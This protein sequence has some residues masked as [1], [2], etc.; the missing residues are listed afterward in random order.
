MTY[1]TLKL[2]YDQELATVTLN[3]PEKRNA[4][5]LDMMDELQAALDGIEAGPARAVILTGAGPAFCAG[6]DLAALRS[7]PPPGNPAVPD[8]SRRAAQLFRRIYS[9]TK[10]LIA[11]VNGPALAG[12]CGIATLC[13]FTLASPEAKFGY[14]ETRI[15][16]MPAL[17]AVFLVRQI[18]EKRARELLLSARVFE[19]REAQRLGLVD[20]V[21]APGMLMERARE[22]ASQLFELSPTSL[23][24][25]KRLLAR[26]S[27]DQ[28]DRELEIALGE[29][30][31]IRSTADFQEGLAAFFEK[32]KPAWTRPRGPSPRP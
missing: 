9:F 10:P 5:S 25:T 17:V 13:D 20:E 1:H 4:L 7:A 16:F 19:A 28:L 27:A 11:A 21:V 32:R 3:R 30:A 22:L 24:S 2:A 14:T 8:D 29:S 23:A 6:M 31:R 15:G 18:G 12:G 26:L